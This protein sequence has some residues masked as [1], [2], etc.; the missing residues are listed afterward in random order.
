MV[1]FDFEVYFCFAKSV[2]RS[3]FDCVVGRAPQLDASFRSSATIPRTC[4]RHSSGRAA[5]RARQQHR[6]DDV[7]R[8]PSRFEIV[9]STSKKSE[10]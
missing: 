6:L 10:D 3:R 8:D 4:A 1:I 9:R 2:E 7:S 5:R